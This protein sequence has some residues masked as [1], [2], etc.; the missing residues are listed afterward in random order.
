MQNFAQQVH[1]FEVAKNRFAVLDHLCDKNRSTRNIITTKIHAQIIQWP[2]FK[3]DLQDEATI[4][5]IMTEELARRLPPGQQ[6]WER[7]QL[8]TG[9]GFD[10]MQ[11]GEAQ[12]GTAFDIE[13]SGELHWPKKEAL[14]EYARQAFAAAEYAISF[15]GEEQFQETERLQSDDE[16][17]KESLAKTGTV[18]N[19][20]M[21]HLVH[22]IH[23][24]GR[25]LLF[26][27]VNESEREQYMN[28]VISHG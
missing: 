19:A 2:R 26:G 7:E 13:I 5:G 15:I 14:L 1:I 8:A 25:S 21:E 23:Q 28:R 6:I 10:P 24:F 11:L 18:G 17:M 27:W 22:N 12:I 9:W 16:Y 4:P 20:L 3:R